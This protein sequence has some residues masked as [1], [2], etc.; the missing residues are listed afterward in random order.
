MTPLV[1]LSSSSVP[2]L[3]AREL[4]EKARQAGAECLDLRAQRGQ[5]WEAGDFERL[6]DSMPVAFVGAGGR[7]GAGVDPSSLPAPLIP[8]LVARGI[9]LRLF[10]A[11]LEEPSAQDA[12]RADVQRIRD[13]WGDGL[14][15]CV[16]VHDERP[17]LAQIDRE[18]AATGVGVVLDSLGLARLGATRDDARKLVAR[19]GVAVQV[20]GFVR[21]R[22]G[23]RHTSLASRPILLDEAR[24]L[25]HGSD[26]PVTVETK[27]GTWAQDVA[28][29]R[30]AL[31]EVAR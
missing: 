17:T 10:S 28:S 14:R 11:P 1:G 13:V 24:E 16:E 2:G 22:D 18:L 31:C 9:P 20:K 21:T 4:V 25:V 19:Y 26:L 27:A 7:L 15:L 30:S 6:L 12:F 5:A 23:Y 8:H 3:G 29:L